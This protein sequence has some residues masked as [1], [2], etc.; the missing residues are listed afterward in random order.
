MGYTVKQ[1]FTYDMELL[2]QMSGVLLVIRKGKPQIFS[3]MLYNHFHLGFS[4]WTTFFR[5]CYGFTCFWI[6]RYPC[7]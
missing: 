3:H 2:E 7:W 6:D 1:A 5:D 4:H